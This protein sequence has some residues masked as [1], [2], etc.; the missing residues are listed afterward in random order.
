[1]ATK[2]LSPPSKPVTVKIRPETRRKLRLL[3]A[4]MDK[5]MMEVL[6][7]LVNDAVKRSQVE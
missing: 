7:L 2:K 6:D 3:A 1:M 5:Q 4:I